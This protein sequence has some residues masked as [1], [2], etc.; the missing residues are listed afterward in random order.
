MQAFSKI[1][2]FISKYNVTCIYHI[3]TL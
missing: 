2:N 3:T 1:S